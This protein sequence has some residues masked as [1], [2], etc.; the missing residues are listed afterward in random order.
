MSVAI[1]NPQAG[2]T[3]GCKNHFIGYKIMYQRCSI[4]ARIFCDTAFELKNYVKPCNFT[5]KSL[6][7][8]NGGKCL[9]IRGD[10]RTKSA[11]FQSDFP[12]LSWDFKACF[13]KVVKGSALRNVCLAA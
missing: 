8:P 11:T 13:K 1:I 2:V 10:T 6:R 9:L 5:S 12:M 4:S 7:K 3:C